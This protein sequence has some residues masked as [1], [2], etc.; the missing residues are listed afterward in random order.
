MRTT[1]AM[2]AFWLAA[3]GCANDPVYIDPASGPMPQ[4]PIEGG[5]TDAMGNPI[6]A[7]ASLVLPIRHE[8]T[9]EAAD[10][11]KKQA[12]LAMDPAHAGVEIPFVKIG[13][14]EVSIE[15]KITNLDA[16]PGEARILLEG[17]NQ[18]FAYDSTML[19]LS[20]DE[21]APPPPALSGDIP[22]A[23][24]G[25]GSL[26]GLF[27]EDEIREAAIDLDQI[28]R[29]NVNPFR[30]TLTTSKNATSFDQLTPLMLVPA[31]QD[32]PPQTST[33][34]VF[35]REAFAQ[36]LRFDLV[37]VADRHMTLAYNIRVRDTR[38]IL[39]DELLD[40]PT[41]QFEYDPASFMPPLFTVAAAPP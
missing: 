37:F 28:T 35:P 20:N 9:T 22:L 24:P 12:L 18:F 7:R 34:I 5:L 17:A 26:E 13:D 27:R 40:A 10:R 41:A 38:G 8:K 23:V 25:N 32:P 30:A 36:M 31:D 15:W 29:G 19:V 6:D 16:M 14:I 11:A 2:T 1:L 4:M 3:T 21:E 39:T 33:G